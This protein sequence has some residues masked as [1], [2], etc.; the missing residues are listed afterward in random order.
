MAKVNEKELE[1]SV[2]TIMDYIRNK[3]TRNDDLEELIG[4]IGEGNT[5][6]SVNDINLI[7]EFL[8]DLQAYKRIYGNL[9][10]GRLRAA[11]K[12]SEN[13]KG[14]V[15]HNEIFIANAVRKALEE[16]CNEYENSDENQEY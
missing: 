14:S 10:I 15:F 6:L 12:P 1:E 11:F 5:E 7:Y 13:R 4:R 8:K 9:P 16:V 2:R 3:T